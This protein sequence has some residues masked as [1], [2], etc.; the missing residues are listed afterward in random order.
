MQ[1]FD[2]IDSYIATFPKSTQALLEEVRTTIQKA[3]P[4]AEECIN[5]GMP[6]FKLKGNMVHFAAYANHIGFYPA[7]SGIS[8]FADELL[9]YKSAKG[10]VQFPIDQPLPLDLIKR[11]SEFRAKENLE[12][13]ALKSIKKAKKA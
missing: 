3:V 7:P 9:G 8:T 13:D 10:S 4:E 5:Y 1:N 11:I 12:L 6:T 2:D